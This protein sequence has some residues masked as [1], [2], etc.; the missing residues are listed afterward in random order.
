MH[1]GRTISQGDDAH[2]GDLHRR[3]R[4]KDR[5]W[6]G[7]LETRQSERQTEGRRPNRGRQTRPARRPRR[8]DE[9]GRPMRWCREAEG[10]TDFLHAATRAAQTTRRSP[11][12]WCFDTPSAAHTVWFWMAPRIPR[13]RQVSR[14]NS[15]SGDDGESRDVHGRCETGTGGNALD[16]KGAGK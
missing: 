6:L 16:L 7:F 1:D 10:A 4:T 2:E 3:R 8:P 13:P 9:Q 12:I 5:R 15:V 11:T 14:R